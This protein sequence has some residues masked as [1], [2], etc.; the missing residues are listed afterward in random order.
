M[1]LIEPEEKTVSGID[2]AEYTFIISKVPA[3]VGREI[4]ATYPVS[5]MPKLGDYEVNEKIML[6]MMKYVAAIKEGNEIRLQTKELIDNHCK[7]WQVLAKLEMAML[8]YN[9]SF[10]GNGKASKV[11]EGFGEKVQQLILKI[12]MDFSEQSSRKK[13]PPSTN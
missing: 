6:K 11:L 8:E 5:A 2:G 1:N 12:L 7:D 13:K 4:V 9:T 10:F 3:T